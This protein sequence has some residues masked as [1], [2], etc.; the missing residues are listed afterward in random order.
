MARE[1]YRWQAA[2]LVRNNTSALTHPE[3]KF[4]KDNEREMFVLLLLPARGLDISVIGS[5]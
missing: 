2:N 1:K 3:I 5:R 4:P